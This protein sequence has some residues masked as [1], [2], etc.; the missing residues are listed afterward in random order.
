MPCP[1]LSC[2]VR[3]PLDCPAGCA[4]PWTVLQGAPCPGLSCRA[5]PALDCRT[6][7]RR[8]EA[9]RSSLPQTEQTVKFLFAQC[10]EIHV[11]L[12]ESR[13][14]QVPSR[15]YSPPTGVMSGSQRRSLGGSWRLSSILVQLV[16]CQSLHHKR[17]DWEH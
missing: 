7:R 3:P 15:P 8:L 5:R 10:L 6:T 12:T 1:G 2:R 9:K 11:T 13:R 17:A 4:L 16:G 14:P